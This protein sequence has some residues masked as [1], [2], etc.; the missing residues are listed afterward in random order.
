MVNEFI[1]DSKHHW[2]SDQRL[3]APSTL[4]GLNC[5]ELDRF[6]MALRMNWLKRYINLRYEDYWT[7]ILDEVM[8]SILWNCTQSINN[9]HYHLLCKTSAKF[10]LPKIPKPYTA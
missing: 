10:A 5:I 1:R 3:Y 8:V 4:G 7:S 9:L 2:I 6:F